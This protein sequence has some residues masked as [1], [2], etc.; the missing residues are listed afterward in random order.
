MSIRCG[1]YVRVSTDDQRDNGFSID[2]QL[3]MLKEHCIKNDY[4]VV[5]IYNDAGHSGKDLLRPE[6]QRLLKDI[7]AK[8]ID[9]LLAI[10]VDRVTRNNYDGFWLLNYLEEH[11]VK[12][13]LILEPYDV[14][15]ANGEMIFGMNLVFGQRERKEIAA[16]TKRAL[17]QMAIEKVHPGKAPFGYVRNKE[18]GHL[19][20][21]PLESL[22]VKEMFE[23][24]ANGYSTRDI[25]KYMKENNRSFRGNKWIWDRIYRMLINPVYIGKFAF[26]LHARKPQDILYVEDYCEPIIDEK[27]WNKTR[28][29]LETNKHPNYGKNIHLFTS[30]IKCPECNEIM[31]SRIAYKNSGKPNKKAY[32]H[33]TCRNINCKSKGVHYNAEK[34][35]EKLVR[36]L[37]ELTRYIYDMDNEILVSNYTKNKELDLI[38]KAISKLQLQEKKLVDL[39]LNSSLNVEAINQKSENIKKEIVKLNNKKETFKPNDKNKEFTVNLIKKLDVEQENNE[40][41]FKKN[42]TFAYM[43]KSLNKK[44]KKEL[45]NK[46]ISSIEIK[47]DKNLNIEIKNINFTDEFISKNTKEYIEYLN[48]ILVDNNQGIVYKEIITEENIKKLSKNNYI[49]SLEKYVNKVLNNDEL[50][51][52]TKLIQEKFYDG[53]III[54]PYIENNLLIEYLILIQK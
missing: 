35:E 38:D 19:E 33:L 15:T 51:K 32:Y 22:V 46:F 41:I 28:K 30:L 9:V 43:F 17:E 49:I 12:I 45:I 48:D 24:C 6:M 5:D 7:K 39:Y 4:D 52:Y 53:G 34:I 25:S 27:I 29:V 21:E 54:S 23:L 8:K 18:T 14:A 3:R 37:N 11:D 26:G 13:E 2:S 44:S 47:R 31:S 10:K 42:F 16:R 1:I 40:Y 50:E 20:I 36:V